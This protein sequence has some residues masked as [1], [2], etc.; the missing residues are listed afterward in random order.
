MRRTRQTR[1]PKRQSRGRANEC[2]LPLVWSLDLME[3]VDL[4]RA[5]KGLPTVKMVCPGFHSPSS[6]KASAMY[7]LL[8]T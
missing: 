2:E 4:P 6:T 3:V 1:E 5:D 7:L 8:L